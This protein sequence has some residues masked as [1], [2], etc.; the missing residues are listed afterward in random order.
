MSG[1][2]CLGETIVD[3]NRIVCAKKIGI[4]GKIS[5]ATR[6]ESGAADY[7]IVPLSDYNNLTSYIQQQSQ[8]QIEIERLTRENEHLRGVLAAMPG[9]GEDYK[10]A[11]IEFEHVKQ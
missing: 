5:F 8:H 3:L 11:K 7:L 6:S 4:E 1:L 2:V 10:R 9:F